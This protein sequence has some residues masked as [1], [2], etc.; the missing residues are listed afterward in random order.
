MK[1][2]LV[3]LSGGQDSTT[4]LFWAKE[5]FEEVHAVTFDYG[6]KHAMELEAAAYIAQRAKVASHEIV[7]VG[8]ILK[9]TSPLVN[10]AEAVEQ[11]A[12]AEVLPGGLEK[13]F[14]PARNLLFLTLAANRA[15]ALGCQDLV[16][17]VCEEDF[18]GYPDCRRSFIQSMELTIDE[19][20]GCDRGTFSIHTPLM[21]LNKATSVELALGLPGCMEAL[22]FSHTCYNG[23]VPPCGH[24]HACLLRQRG[25]DQAGVADP[26]RVR[27]YQEKANDYSPK[28]EKR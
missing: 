26:L 8:N 11:Y 20:L 14:V 17:G 7:E 6:Q 15:A 10:R 18:G 13:T 3:V 24:C 28:G 2:C 9:S 22:A 23:N 12:S 27:L 19:A 4:C 5:I 25:F 16:T 21:N 1:K